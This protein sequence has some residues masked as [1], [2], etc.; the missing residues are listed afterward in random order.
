MLS[1]D[2]AAASLADLVRDLERLGWRCEVSRGDE[3]IVIAIDGKGDVQALEKTLAERGDVEVIP[4][5]QKREYHQ[6]RSRRKLMTGLAAGLGLLTAVA[7]GA[8]LVGFLLPPKGTLA[9]RNLVRAAKKGEIRELE[10]KL[11]TLLGKPVLLVHLEG[12][13]Y[14]ALSAICT[15]MDICQLEWKADRRQ[16]VCPCHGGAFDLYGNVVQGPPSVPLASFA[17]EPIGDEL[18]LRREG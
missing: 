11:V 15:H 14:F 16:L 4:I 18:Y 7:A 6:L 9:D 5:L 10:A 3:Q 8:P 13:R 12:E 2:Y 17:V 1:N